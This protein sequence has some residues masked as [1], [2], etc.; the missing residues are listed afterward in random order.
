MY[1]STTALSPTKPS[2]APLSTTQSNISELQPHFT[3]RR[4][5][6]N[7]YSLIY[8][9][10]TQNM[11]ACSIT[12]SQ[13]KDKDNVVGDPSDDTPSQTQ[14]EQNILKL[15]TSLDNLKKALQGEQAPELERLENTHKELMQALSKFSALVKIIE[16]LNNSNQTNGRQE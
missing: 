9:H 1:K 7:Y 8:P 16:A 2:F 3:A 5:Q 4:S 11:R 13:K 12:Q 15:K 10:T 6:H 14:L